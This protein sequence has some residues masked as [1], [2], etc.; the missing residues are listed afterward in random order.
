MNQFFRLHGQFANRVEGQILYSTLVGPWNRELVDAWSRDA[1]LRIAHF[2]A[3]MPYVCITTVQQSIVC[4]PD[5]MILLGRVERFGQEKMHC[6]GNAIVADASVD[7]RHLVEPAY[8]RIGLKIFFD[9]FDEAK[10]WAEGIL[11]DF[12]RAKKEGIQCDKSLPTQ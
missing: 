12:Q 8:A 10:A 9:E 5:A 3:E 1:F 6:L 7:G 4:P 2:T 11:G